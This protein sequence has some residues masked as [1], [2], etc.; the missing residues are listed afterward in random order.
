MRF[1]VAL[2]FI[3]ATVS[4]FA[5][6]PGSV[7]TMSASAAILKAPR[8]KYPYSAKKH[9]SGGAGVFVLHTD[10]HTGIVS[11]VTVQKSM[12]SS[13]LDQCAIDALRRWRFKPDTLLARKSS[14]R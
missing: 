6:K 11:S 8:P 14:S 5:Q 9:G 7:T 12:G 1:F 13:L 10:Q 4:S 2:A 3:A